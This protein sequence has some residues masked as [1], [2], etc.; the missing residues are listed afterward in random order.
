MSRPAR[1]G[2]AL[3]SF[4][5]RRQRLRIQK[6]FQKYSHIL[7]VTP[8][9]GDVMFRRKPLPVSLIALVTMLCVSF[10]PDLHAEKG[11]TPSK[12]RSTTENVEAVDADTV[13]KT[14]SPKKGAAE[15][16]DAQDDIAANNPTMAVG[17]DLSGGAIVSLSHN[18]GQGTLGTLIPNQRFNPFLQTQF[19]TSFFVVVY[20]LVLFGSQTASIEWTQPDGF[21][22]S[23]LGFFG[24]PTFGGQYNFALPGGFI[25]QPSAGFRAPISRISRAS[26]VVGGLFGGGNLI[27]MPPPV[28]GLILRAG[29]R[30]Q[31]NAYVPQLRNHW[32]L[33]KGE[34]VWIENN[35]KLISTGP[36][37]A[38]QGTTAAESCGGIPALGQMSATLAASYTRWGFT[39]AGSLTGFGFL[40]A[41][42]AN[43][44]FTSPNAFAYTFPRIFSIGSLSMG[45]RFNSWFALTGG[46]TSFQ[47]WNM[48]GSYIPRFPFW[49]FVSP[50]NNFSTAFITTT[51]NIS[52]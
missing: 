16:D 22:G 13:E 34:D 36:C 28:P 47:P 11:K 39:W 41:F 17:N 38:R 19:T 45:Y 8:P 48:V 6:R 14:A 24:D 2:W 50:A 43:D 35:T 7:N 12:E 4:G 30:V 10:S 37:L 44:Q 52:P 3:L 27:W 5:F 26:G 46:L 49:D 32:G 25:L 9:M 51:F 18:L 40:S 31:G 20:G 42:A 23:R 29:T 21:G 1:P 15:A 33:N